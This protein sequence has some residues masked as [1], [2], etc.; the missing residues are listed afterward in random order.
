[1]GTG[2]APLGNDDDG[3]Q[4]HAIAHR[5]HDVAFDVVVRRCDDF[6]V[7]RNVAARRLRGRGISEG[8][9]AHAQQ[10]GCGKRAG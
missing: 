3:V 10:Q 8:R 7:R 4:H 5:Y 2:F 6:E 9:G 1:M